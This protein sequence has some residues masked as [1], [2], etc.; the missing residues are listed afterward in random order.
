MRYL[1]LFAHRIMTNFV[2]EGW[3][4]SRREGLFLISAMRGRVKFS[5]KSE[6]EGGPQRGEVCSPAGDSNGKHRNYFISQTL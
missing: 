5:E 1:R 4:L 6:P 3:H 2:G